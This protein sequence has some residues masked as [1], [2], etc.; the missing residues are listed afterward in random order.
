MRR[1]LYDADHEAFRSVVAEFV[2]REVTPH[3]ARWDEQ[4][5]IDRETWLAAGRQGIL[6]LAAPEEYGGGGGT[7]YRFRAVLLEELAK[8]HATSLASSFSLQDDIAIP[9]I[10]EIGTDEQKRRW[11]PA[12]AAGELIGAIAMTEPGTGS[13]L[14]GIRTAARQVP[15]GW[16]VNGAKT[17]ITNGIQSDLVITV[18]RTDPDGGA[19]GFSL[20]VVERDMPGFSR[21]RKLDKV[22]LHAQDT[23]E[24]VY[25][26]VFVPDENVLGRI[27]GG[28]GQL[29]EML[30]LERLSIA[31]HALAVSEAILAD[32]IGYVRDRHAFGQRLADF[33]NTQFE[34]AE[35][36]TEVSIGRVFVDR[37]ILA[38]NAGELTE[39]DAAMAKWWGA[40]LQ[41]RVVDR[42]L[43]LHGGYGFML[44]Y[45]VGRAYQDARIQRIFGGAN[46]IM[47]Q[48]IG[49]SIVGRP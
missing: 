44:E 43:Q 15:G 20:L 7:D 4:R 22:G 12:M 29:R 46:E 27:G 25:E 35:M 11:L 33:Q 5:L 6:G 21:G 14:K 17:F 10:R 41:N 16:V 47:K 2:E 49:R 8:V 45:P 19:A 48:I 18:A 37:A 32:T 1:E 42:C 24:L 3:L 23:A 30:P 40:D 28:F 39:V 38:L 31:V 34:L 26:D 36:Q 13:D 9:Y